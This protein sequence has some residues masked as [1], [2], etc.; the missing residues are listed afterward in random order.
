V[1]NVIIKQFTFRFNP[2]NCKNSSYPMKA[3]SIEVK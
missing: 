3:L 1:G 2:E